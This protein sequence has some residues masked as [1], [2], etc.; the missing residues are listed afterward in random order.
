MAAHESWVKENAALVP[1]LFATYKDAERFAAQ[2]PDE[3]ARII[4]RG[5]KIPAEV[6]RQVMDK[7]R[8]RIRV[9]WASE[10]GDDIKAVFEAA[11]EAGVLDQVP[12]SAIIY[13]P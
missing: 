6:I 7:D 1:R 10:L 12:D 8:M 9:A 5:T 11:R 3:A 2:H 13:R 4:A